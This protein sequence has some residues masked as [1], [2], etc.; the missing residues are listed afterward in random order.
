MRCSRGIS[1][2]RIG[3]S[4]LDLGSAL[5]GWWRADLGVTLNGSTVA[6]WADQSGN[7]RTATQGTAG[8][9]PTYVSSVSGLNNQPAFA[10]TTASGTYLSTA[11]G[12]VVTQPSTLVVV[13]RSGTVTANLLA[14]DGP[15]G[16][17]RR[18][19]IGV[20][21]AKQVQSFAGTLLN[22]ATLWGDNTS[23]IALAEFNGGSSAI[24]LDSATATIAS[25]A[26]GAVSFEG[27][28]IGGS[29]TGT[30]N[31]QGHISEV[32]AI[33]GASSAIRASVV[34]YLGTRYAITVT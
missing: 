6:A 18:Q 13:S 15:L 23:R 30:Q 3:W 21:A 14:I 11:V 32:I 7:G 19:L 25:G 9:Q 28:L 29:N 5:L 12:A 34:R 24:Y 1:G 20:N 4:P 22:S 10:F 27:V 8:K 31:W 2:A 16:G 17:T 26:A 33:S